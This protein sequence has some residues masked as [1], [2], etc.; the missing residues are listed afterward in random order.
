[1]LKLLYALAAA[2][3]FRLLY[4]FACCS[5]SLHIAVAAADGN[6]WQYYLASI[7]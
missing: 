5:Y 7:P 4:R 2:A 6:G 1:M 3:I